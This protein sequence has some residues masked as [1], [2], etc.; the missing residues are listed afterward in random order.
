MAVLEV[1]ACYTS[2]GEPPGTSCEKTGVAIMSDMTIRIKQYQ[3]AEMIF[4]QHTYNGYV[5]AIKEYL[6]KFCNAATF[7]SVF[8]AE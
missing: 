6:V 4:D 1:L 5:V 2:G 7:S 3:T 8:A